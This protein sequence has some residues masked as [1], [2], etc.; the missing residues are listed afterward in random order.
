MEQQTQE[1]DCKKFRNLDEQIN[2]LRDRGLVIEDDIKAKEFLY[3]NNY[4]RVSGYSLTLRNHDIFYPNTKFQNII[5][6]YS[7][8]QELRNMLL[9]YLEIIEIKIKSI[10][11]YEFT[12]K[13]GGIGYL[14]SSRFFCNVTYNSIMH[15]ANDQVDKR[16]SHEAYLKHFIEELKTPIPMWAYIDLLTI[17]DISRLYGISENDIQTLVAS[18]FGLNH[19]TAVDTMCKFL[20]CITIIRNLCAHGSRLYNRLFITK[21]SLNKAEQAILPKDVLGNPDNSR[22][23]GFI[24]NIKRLLS[25]DQFLSFKLD[26]GNLNQKYPFVDMKHYGFC[27][28]WSHHL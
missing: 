15:K 20:H 18:A 6:I 9:K 11:T 1:L 13:H 17:S 24:I 14:D 22:L 21:P 7:F 2:I 10:Y 26:I 19:R 28:D 12:K 5:D 16:K 27:D 25:E 3:N 4:Y 23:F 8:D